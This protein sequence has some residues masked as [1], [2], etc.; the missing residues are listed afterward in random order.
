MKFIVTLIS[1]V[2]I[3]YMASAQ[4]E[5]RKIYGS[6]IEGGKV[7]NYEFTQN[8]GVGYSLEFLPISQTNPFESMSKSF[9]AL[10]K[11]DVDSTFKL[12]RKEI[13]ITIKNLDETQKSN[14]NISPF[15][16]SE[17]TSK[18]TLKKYLDSLA[19]VDSSLNEVIKAFKFISNKI[20]LI[21]ARQEK[22][23]TILN[24]K[25]AVKLESFEKFKKYF[26]EINEIKSVDSVELFNRFIKGD[27]L[28]KYFNILKSEIDSKAVI[29]SKYQTIYDNLK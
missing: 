25:D 3:T 13:G 7:F 18:K 15:L 20:N 10:E 6:F 16:S 17:D 29:T 2:L 12:L 8:P 22:I 11:L 23:P 9:A 27:S 21:K 19:K 14:T 1:F 28:I 5:I 24:N 4:Q 26:S